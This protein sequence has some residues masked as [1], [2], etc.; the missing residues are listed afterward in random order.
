MFHVQLTAPA[1]SDVL[2]MRPCAELAPLLYVTTIVHEVLGAVD[3]AAKP[4]PLRETGDRTDVNT[5]VSG[6][7]VGAAVAG[8]RVGAGVAGACVVDG[9]VAGACV[10]AAV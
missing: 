4:V 10:G 8:A 6:F 9:T 1:A 2:G 7:S 5:T 3:T